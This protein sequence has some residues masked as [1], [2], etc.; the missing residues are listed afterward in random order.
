MRE[1][2]SRRE[3]ALRTAAVACLAAL[4]VVQVAGLPYARGQ[5]PHIAALALALAAAAG[6]VAI[7]LVTAGA[8]GGRAVWRVVAA[9]GGLVVG[10]WVATRALAVPGIAEDAGHWTTARGVT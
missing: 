9:L 3:A 2:I 8:A 4:A 7:A 6:G 5:G 1:P 10:G